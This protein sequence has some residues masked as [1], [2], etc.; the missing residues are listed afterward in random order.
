MNKSPSTAPFAIRNPFDLDSSSPSLP[1]PVNVTAIHRSHHHQNDLFHFDGSHRSHH[2]NQQQYS[3]P[4]NNSPSFSYPKLNQNSPV[5]VQFKNHH[6]RIPK[7][8]PCFSSSSTPSPL[9]NCCCY[10]P[11]TEL[12]LPSP[13]STLSSRTSSPSIMTHNTT[14]TSARKTKVNIEKKKRKRKKKVLF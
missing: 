7:T 12:A 13:V 6:D 2:L 9:Y 5:Y 1:L 8:S 10:P 14:G 11:S 4:I 3:L